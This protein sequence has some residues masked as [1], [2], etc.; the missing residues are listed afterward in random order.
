[1]AVANTC[2]ARCL[3]CFP[4]FQPLLALSPRPACSPVLSKPCG[5]ITALAVTFWKCVSIDSYF[6]NPRLWFLSLGFVT[7]LNALSRIATCLLRFPWKGKIVLLA[8]LKH[9]LLDSLKH[10]LL[11]HCKKSQPILLPTLFP[12]W[13]HPGLSSSHPQ[14]HKHPQQAYRLFL[15]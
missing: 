10:D 1:M 12:F 15:F 5:C 4:P 9:V 3:N 11:Y 6:L 8:S 7:A 2:S 14:H 13:E